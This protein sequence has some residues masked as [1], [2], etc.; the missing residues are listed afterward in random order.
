MRLLARLVT[1][2]VVA[3]LFATPLM[4]CVME[5]EQ[6]S[7]SEAEC[8]KVMAGDCHN[9]VGPAS[10]KCCRSVATV[11]DA[12]KPVRATSVAPQTHAVIAAPVVIL[13]FASSTFATVAADSSPPGSPPVCSSVLR[14]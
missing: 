7:V 9:Q 1:L 8:C 4:A 10:H 11:P 3:F 2:G 12:T 6:M 14:I 13:V 5:A